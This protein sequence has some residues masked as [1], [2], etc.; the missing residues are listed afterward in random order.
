MVP[1]LTHPQLRE[2]LA[3][4]VLDALSADEQAAVLAHAATCAE[5]GPALTALRDATAQLAYVV[6]RGPDD[7]AGRARV[8]NR[9][10]ARARADLAVAAV[11]AT[12]VDARSGA[13]SPAVPP[14]GDPG[15]AA[16]AR[17]TRAPAIAVGRTAQRARQTSWMAS[18][19]AA[20]SVA[21]AIGVAAVVVATTRETRLTDDVARMARSHAT[22][23]LQIAR[24]HDSVSAED[25][26]WRGLTGPN[27]SIIRLSSVA[28]HAAWGWMF[29]DHD[30]N[31]W[32]LLARNLEA[33]PPGRSYQLWLVTRREK[34]SAGILTPGPGGSAELQFTNALARDALR[35]IVVTQEA[36]DGA[37][38]P[39][40]ASVMTAGD[41]AVTPAIPRQP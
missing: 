2:M 16:R 33:P 6:P 23:S 20:W 13:S 14:A 5:C 24:L 8:R 40:G 4:A 17:V 30:A 29:W 19:I 41:G 38:Q 28:P 7:P 35:M 32:T 37:A 31:Q 39:T 3:D 11:D 34:V 9:L 27:V 10:L 36:A 21:G 15:G 22:D 18:P 12:G 26:I 25:S 1:D